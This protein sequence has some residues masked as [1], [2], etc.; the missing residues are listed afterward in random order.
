LLSAKRY[1]R[2][3]WHL[4]IYYEHLQFSLVAGIRQGARA[5]IVPIILN[6]FGQ[7]TIA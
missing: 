6:C 5:I 2:S 7:I 1:L 4:S 3:K